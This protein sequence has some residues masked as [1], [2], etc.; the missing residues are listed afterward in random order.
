MLYPDGRRVDQWRPGSSV[1]DVS[2]PETKLYF[3]LLARSFIDAGF[4]AIHYGQVEIMNGND[5]DLTHWSQVFTLA[6]SYAATHARRHMVLCD[7]H[8][9]HGGLVRDGHLLL[10]YRRARHRPF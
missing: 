9:P 5:P 6:R 2:R 8:V 3:Y 7:A 10:D 1:P 4:E